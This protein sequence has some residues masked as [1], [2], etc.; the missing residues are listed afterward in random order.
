MK[1][2]KNQK[3]VALIGGASLELNIRDTLI[4]SFECRLM[5]VHKKY[6]GKRLSCTLIKEFVRKVTSQGKISF[7]H[8]ISEKFIAKPVSTIG[9]F[10]SDINETMKSLKKP[11]I[12][13]QIRDFK[14][15]DT[16]PVL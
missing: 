12:F 1:A 10:R 4:D 3:L 14:D 7:G 8:F 5:C 16:I 9:L 15:Q 11:I 13:G 6:H 2:T